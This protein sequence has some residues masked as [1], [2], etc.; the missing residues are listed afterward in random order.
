MKKYQIPSTVCEAL[1]TGA[2]ICTSPNDGKGSF[3]SPP[4]G[5]GKE[6]APRRV[7]TLYI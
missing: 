3:T 2:I 6:N 7:G 4:G 5:G 1:L